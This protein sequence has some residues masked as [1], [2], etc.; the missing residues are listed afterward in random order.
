LSWYSMEAFPPETP[1]GKGTRRI[2][3]QGLGHTE[4]TLWTGEPAGLLWPLSVSAANK[5]PFTT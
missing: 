3:H 1:I 2:L 5:L 4:I